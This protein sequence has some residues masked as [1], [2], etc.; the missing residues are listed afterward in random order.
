MIRNE[1]KCSSSRITMKRQQCI[2]GWSYFFPAFESQLVLQHTGFFLKIL[3]VTNY[4]LYIDWEREIEDIGTPKGSEALR[5][6]YWRNGVQQKGCHGVVISVK[7]S[8]ITNTNRYIKNNIAENVLKLIFS[9]TQSI[10]QLQAISTLFIITLCTRQ[11][12]NG[13]DFC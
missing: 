2:S 9:N 3:Y 5:L 12:C 10:P 8:N 4:T 1:I 6:N 11:L 7:K 13:E